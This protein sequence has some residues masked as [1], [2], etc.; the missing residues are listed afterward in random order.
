ML[1]GMNYALEPWHDFA[2]TVAGLA[3]AL[4]GLLF[5]ALSIKSA[6][7]EGSVSLRSRA[8]QTLTLFLTSA[9]SAIV[10]VAP[11][12]R[13]GVAV[14]LLVLAAVSGAALFILDRRAGHDSTSSVARYIEAASPNMVTSVL[15]GVA[16]LTLLLQGG[17]GL[18]WLIPAVLAGLVGGV[19]RSGSAHAGATEGAAVSPGW[20]Y[21]D[22]PDPEGR[23][24]I[25]AAVTGELPGEALRVVFAGRPHDEVPAVRADRPPPGGK[26]LGQAHHLVV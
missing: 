13:L 23:L 24:R 4:T 5:V 10:L 7:L 17:G 21:I 25:S 11:Q 1:G 8:A 12:P 9:I 19:L 3:G 2:V 22:P 16:G 20:I 6:A 18:Y 26:M 15:T 14:E